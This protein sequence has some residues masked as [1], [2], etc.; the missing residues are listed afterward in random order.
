[1]NRPG[2]QTVVCGGLN[3]VFS[4]L[5]AVGQRAPGSLAFISPRG[6]ANFDRLLANIRSTASAASKNGIKPGQLVVL[7]VRN[8]DVLM[9]L[10]LALM[11]IG[12]RVGLTANLPLYDAAAVPVDVVIADGNIDTHGRHLIVLNSSWFNSDKAAV[13]EPLD[14]ADACS[15]ITSS[16]GSTGTPKLIEMLACGMARRI[17][18]I[19]SED[20]TTPGMR[21][22]HLLGDRLL[23]N[24][25]ESLAVL[26][27]GGITM[28]IRDRHPATILDAIQLYCPD[29]ITMS[30]SKVVEILEA[31]KGRPSQLNRVK[32]LR[33]SG[34][35]LAPDL[36]ALVQE[37]I[38]DEAFSVYGLTETGWIARGSADELKS[39]PFS[40]GR[41]YDDIEIAA[42]DDRDQSLPVGE[43]G[44]IR[45]RLPEDEL[46]HYLGR[47][48]LTQSAIRDGW[49]ST[50]DIGV[51]DE[52]RTLLIK[53][54]TSNVINVGGDKVSPEEIEQHILAHLG[55]R[56]VAVTGVRR[57]E[58]FEKIFAFVVSDGYPSIAEI[59]AH[60]AKRGSWPIEALEMV[61]EIP[62]TETGKIDR[63]ALKELCAQVRH[64]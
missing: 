10:T 12:C 2:K 52:N 30:A 46:G 51:I 62:R 37:K 9:I 5:E 45:V 41:I 39:M 21:L 60:L 34:A 36:R 7:A 31:L 53:G 58:G 55:I 59:N 27:N 14:G 15:L 43:E 3:D 1:M 16:S 44:E 49:F 26:M 28:K 18:R 40:A 17:N 33:V 23:G 25:C 48:L 42:F 64:S 38:A 24:V 13:S 54:R 50:G 8:T 32:K 35:F 57:S 19:N 4:T 47:D 63:V 20:M 29:Q 56:D 22:M 11:R 6:Q 61:S